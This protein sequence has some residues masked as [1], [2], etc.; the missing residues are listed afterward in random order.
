MPIE[1]GPDGERIFFSSTGRTLADEDQICVLS[2]GVDIGS[3][4]SH[5]I[6]SRIVLERLDSPYVVT[7]R[8]AFYQSHI[9]LPP[10][11]T[12][13]EIDPHAPRAFLPPPSHHST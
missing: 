10:H 7:Q 3:W 4:T 6:F 8:E 11:S 1:Q 2:V 12:A 9:L 5:L 13:E